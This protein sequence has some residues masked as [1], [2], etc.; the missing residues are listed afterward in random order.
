LAICFGELPRSRITRTWANNASS[1]IDNAS[2][3]QV[4]SGVSQH[5]GS[6][7]HDPIPPPHR[8]DTQTDTLPSR[9]SRLN[10]PAI[11]IPQPAP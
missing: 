5:D 1:V 9:A 3:D 4:N 6:N 8:P 2:R 7:R 10:G 11:R